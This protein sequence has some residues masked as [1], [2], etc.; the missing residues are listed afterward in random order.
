M[1]WA[2]WQNLLNSSGN[3]SDPTS[4]WIHNF[5]KSDRE[6]ALR[7][8]KLARQLIILANSTSSDEL[9]QS[10][11]FRNHRVSDRAF[12]VLITLYSVL[13]T[14]GAVGN[15]LVI[16]AVIR[17]PVMRT[18]H[19]AYI[20]N[21]AISDLLLC[22]LTMPLT[23]MEILTKYWMLGHSAITCKLV[24]GLQAVSIFTST[25]TIMAISLDRYQLIVHPNQAYAKRIGAG[26]GLTLVW[27][28]SLLLSCPAFMFRTLERHL[29]PGFPAES[30][31]YCFEEWPVKHGGA[32]YSLAT[33]MLQYAAPVITM[34]VTHTKICRRLELRTIS[35]ETRSQDV[36]KKI[37]ERRRLRRLNVLLTVVA[38]IF[39]V[40]WMPLNVFN[41]VVDLSNPYSEDET[42]SM[43]I[44]YAVCHM[45]GMSSACAN[46]VLYGWLNENFRAVFRDIFSPVLKYCCKEQ[47]SRTPAARQTS[48]CQQTNLLTSVSAAQ[49]L[50]LHTTQLILMNPM[51]VKAAD[52]EEHK[53]QHGTT[54]V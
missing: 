28:V 30:I 5:V 34:C 37:R 17:Q 45:I 40:C 26:V 32:M 48:D 19:N 12:Y 6:Q 42:E 4:W 33:I 20:M 47:Q 43:L 53:L 15:F 39:A 8:A 31:N 22:V 13:I 1:E 35:L 21:L 46:P 38:F 50:V 2:Q 54:S 7:L 52:E 51:T 49:C 24:G 10:H 11:L 9:L 41:F 27:G 25:M 29:L 36:A 23:L 18:L 14:T 3:T 16:Y 44:T